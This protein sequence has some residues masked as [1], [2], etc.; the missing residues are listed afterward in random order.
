MIQNNNVAPATI[1]IAAAV[2]HNEQG[3]MLLV[4]KF[5][6]S[7]FM[8]P[9]GKIGPDETPDLTLIRELREELSIDV[10]VNTLGYLGQFAA[11][12][13]NEP[14]CVVEADVFEVPFPTHAPRP[15]A[16]IEEIL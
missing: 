4:R 14:N 16:E 7:A 11:L 10:G 9:G 5:G 1:K 8:Q 6:T 12:A 15:A 13:A 2:I 3:Q